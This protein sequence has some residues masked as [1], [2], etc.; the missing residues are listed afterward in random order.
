M[1]WLYGNI[2]LG[3]HVIIKLS[4]GVK[5]WGKIL[6]QDSSKTFRVFR[7]NKHKLVILHGPNFLLQPSELS[8]EA[9]YGEQRG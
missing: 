2:L 5:D 6:S 1:W 3:K 7:R 4:E 8:T 9:S